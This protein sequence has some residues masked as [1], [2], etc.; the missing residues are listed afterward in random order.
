MYLYFPLL[1][2]QRFQRHHQYLAACNEW[3]S[4]DFN[5]VLDENE[6]ISD[7]LTKKLK[8]LYYSN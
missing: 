7:S 2:H 4:K 8:L 3:E 6:I 5:S 1:A